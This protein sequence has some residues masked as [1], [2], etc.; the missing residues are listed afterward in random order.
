MIE[1]THKSSTLRQAIAAATVR[2]SSPDT[3]AA[4]QNNTVPKGNVL[5]AARVAG[6]FGVK[7]TA[8]MIPDCHPLPIEFWL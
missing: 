2:V 4:I 6:L 7:R 5:E 8:D 1:I 3:I